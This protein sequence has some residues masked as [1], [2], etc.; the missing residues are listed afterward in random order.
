MPAQPAPW[1]QSLGIKNALVALLEGP[2]G[3]WQLRPGTDCDLVRLLAG[4]AALYLSREHGHALSQQQLEAA[5]QLR[6]P[7]AFDEAAQLVRLLA[8]AVEALQVRHSCQMNGLPSRTGR[9]SSCVL[10]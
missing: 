6:G 8:R 4:T 10:T 9:P 1:Q 7:S 2:P 3:H 5:P